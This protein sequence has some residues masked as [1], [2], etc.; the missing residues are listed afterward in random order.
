MP[1]CF[2]KIGAKQKVNNIELLKSYMK[3]AH[4]KG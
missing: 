1:H 2:C 3:L 4:F